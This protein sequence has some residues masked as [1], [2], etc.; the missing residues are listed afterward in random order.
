MTCSLER[1]I[2]PVTQR[3]CVINVLGSHSVMWEKTALR[4][5]DLTMCGQLAIYRNDEK[6]KRSKNKN[7]SRPSEV[8][9]FCWCFPYAR[10]FCWCIGLRKG[11][12][13]RKHDLPEVLMMTFWYIIGTAVFFPPVFSS[14]G[15]CHVIK[16]IPVVC[17][18]KSQNRH[19]YEILAHC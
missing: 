2:V 9:V 12:W 13:F 7:R 5:F 6:K 18:I 11:K 14:T 19:F 3:W 15:N 10:F 17:H 1:S 16:K 4:V 8:F